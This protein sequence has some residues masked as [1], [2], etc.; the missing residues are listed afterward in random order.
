VKANREVMYA[1][2]TARFLGVTPRTLKRLTDQGVI[3]IWFRT[4][5]GRPVYSRRTI[6]AHQRR[7]GELAAERS[8]S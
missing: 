1:S 7:A 5:T 3:A 6:E 2:E 8:A 4:D